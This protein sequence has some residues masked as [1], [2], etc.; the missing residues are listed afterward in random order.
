MTFPVSGFR[1]K[2]AAVPLLVAAFAAFAAAQ[3]R[4]FEARLSPVPIDVAMQ[5]TIAGTGAATAS[6]DGNRLTITGTFKDLRS[7]A[8]VARLH[9][10][11]RGTRGP[12]FADLSVSGGTSGT[13]SGSI[14]LT[15]GQ[16]GDLGKSLFYVQL[17]SEKAPDGNLRGWLLPEKGKAK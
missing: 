4:V 8:T 2:A 7:P 14:E 13:I 15:K 6:L 5:A 10:A 12:A 3:T 11:Y 17:H 16:I 1:C 9:R